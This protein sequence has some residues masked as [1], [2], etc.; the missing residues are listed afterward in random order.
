MRKAPCGAD[1]TVVCISMYAN[2]FP[3]GTDLHT[4][5]TYLKIETT[6]ELCNS[7]AAIMLIKQQQGSLLLPVIVKYI[8]LGSYKLATVVS[9]FGL[10]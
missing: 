3:V 9:W 6:S 8:L 2:S 10:N 4:S 5:P 7:T 1:A